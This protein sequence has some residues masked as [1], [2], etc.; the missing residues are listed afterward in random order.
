[1]HPSVALAQF[2]DAAPG[3]AKV[4]VDE[5]ENFVDKL[6]GYEGCDVMLYAYGRLIGNNWHNCFLKLLSQVGLIR[7][8]SGVARSMK[9]LLNLM[10]RVE[11]LIGDN[12]IFSKTTCSNL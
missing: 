4:L 3:L 10:K 2:A 12:P 6:C 9:K 5:I 8:E 1:M 7:W 11:N